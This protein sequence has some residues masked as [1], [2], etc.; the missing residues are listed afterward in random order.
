MPARM[1]SNETNCNGSRSIRTHQP[2]AFL[3]SNNCFDCHWVMLVLALDHSQGAHDVPAIPILHP[4]NAFKAE[5][6][7]QPC[8]D[9]GK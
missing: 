9:L 5:T 6:L 3:D 1:D 4:M 8:T 2:D 7:Q